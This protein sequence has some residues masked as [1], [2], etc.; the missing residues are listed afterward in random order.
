MPNRYTRLIVD[1]I[2]SCWFKIEGTLQTLH[3]YRIKD[4]LRV[5]CTKIHFRAKISDKTETDVPVSLFS[6]IQPFKNF[7]RISPSDINPEKLERSVKNRRSG[8]VGYV[9]C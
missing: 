4:K 8:I 7:H 9:V 3:F 1:Y 5:I 6:Q 2:S